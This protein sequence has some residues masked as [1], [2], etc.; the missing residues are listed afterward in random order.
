VLICPVDCGKSDDT[1]LQNKR[2]DPAEIK[3][4]RYTWL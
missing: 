4:E 3:E 1:D 2:N